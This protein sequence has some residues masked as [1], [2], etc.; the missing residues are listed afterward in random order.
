MTHPPLTTRLFKLFS[1]FLLLMASGFSLAQTQQLLSNTPGSA[2][3]APVAATII[4]SNFGYL[5]PLLPLEPLAP[6]VS[7]PANC[8][9]GTG[10]SPGVPACV[11]IG[12]NIT[13]TGSPLQLSAS[14][15]SN[16]N[17]N[18]STNIVL[19]GYSVPGNTCGYSLFNISGTQ[20]AGTWYYPMY[21]VT[22][23]TSNGLASAGSGNVPGQIYFK[24]QLQSGFIGS[25]NL[26][27]F[28]MNINGS[29][30]LT[31]TTTQPYVN[32]Q[33]FT[34][35][36]GVNMGGTDLNYTDAAGSTWGFDISEIHASGSS[37][38]QAESMIEL[39]NNLNYGSSTVTNLGLGSYAPKNKG[40]RGALLDSAFVS[41]SQQDGISPYSTW[42]NVLAI[43]RPNTYSA[44]TSDGSYIQV[45]PRQVP[46][47]SQPLADHAEDYRPTLFTTGTTMYNNAGVDANGNTYAASTVTQSITSQT[48]SV[49]SLAVGPPPVSGAPN[50]VYAQ[51][52]GYISGTT[53]TITSIP[54]DEFI[55]VGN[56]VLSQ[57]NTG[58]T[59]TLTAGTVITALG[60]GQGGVGTYTVNN[61]QTAGSSGTPI[62][63][64]FAVQGGAFF[65]QS[66]NP[67]INFSAPPSGGTTATATIATYGLTKV[68]IPLINSSFIGTISSASGTVSTLTL[69]SGNG[70]SVNG[71]PI[72]TGMVM[73]SATQPGTTL[74]IT[75]CGGGNCNTATTFTIT[76][77]AACA[78]VAQQQMS[79]ILPGAD[80]GCQ[81][82]DILPVTM[83]GGSGATIMVAAVGS[84]G[85]LNGK[86]TRAIVAS[87]GSFTSKSATPT[88][89]I[90]SSHCA[91]AP[92]FTDGNA[93]SNSSTL[94][95][96]ILTVNAGGA[97]GSS[98]GSGYL[99][100]PPP[101]VW[102][103]NYSQGRD[104]PPLLIPT[105]NAATAATLPIPNGVQGTTSTTAPLAGAVGE[106][107]VVD[108][109]NS[110]TSTVTITIAT[111]AVVTWTPPASFV[112]TPAAWTC[113][114]SF[115]TTGALPTGITAATG[116]YWIIGSTYSAGSFQI[117]D[118]A[119]HA[120]AGTNAIAT[121]GSQSGTQTL[122]IG[123][124]YAAAPGTFAVAGLTL[125][126]GDWDCNGQANYQ[127]TA[128]T[129]TSGYSAGMG[130]SSTA[131]GTQDGYN[132]V[133]FAATALANAASVSAPVFSSLAAISKTYYMLSNVVGMS[134]G[135]AV[136]GGEVSCR[137]MR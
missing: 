3:T 56:L 130:T 125:T 58:P 59:V 71:F 93:A 96:G 15:G 85:Y 12:P 132:S 21:Y 126:A 120:M 105:M 51:A 75:A 87:Q 24:Y 34:R 129:G 31:D 23:D 98:A 73:Q 116:V 133:R 6:L 54:S 118:T 53:L 122:Q 43:G 65:G 39:D 28:T 112:A 7:V 52:F 22:T 26:S 32:G 115:T 80:S 41:A 76:C 49:A 69:A 16:T 102:L 95:F 134:A 127:F 99:A 90:G 86:V 13:L 107:Q 46:S 109:L 67:S 63:L 9:L 110:A 100:Y 97:G 36:Q 66:T 119:A 5:W 101:Y 77:S 48:T 17:L 137:R 57:Q 11:T 29:P 61:S 121:S 114:V 62:Q 10:S 55:N 78:N 8:L 84:G 47:Y 64:G 94:G 44:V 20:Q 106:H 131:L 1:F 42:A 104:T 37:Y 18:C 123:A 19:S 74:T 128:A 88:V 108:C 82:G 60:T 68:V 33:V 50:S 70:G 30:D 113:P 72:Q 91:T 117:A 27:E 124:L 81:V 40:V 83:A 135:S 45:I 92:T 38:A 14:V 2:T 111:P 103:A 89:G 4:N 35:I 25:R 136:A 79:A